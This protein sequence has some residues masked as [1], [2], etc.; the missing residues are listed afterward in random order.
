MDSDNEKNI[1]SAGEYFLNQFIL[2]DE[3]VTRMRTQIREL[4]KLMKINL[5]AG[6]KIDHESL[7]KLKHLSEKV[8]RFGMSL[9]GLRD[10][11]HLAFPTSKYNQNAA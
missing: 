10:E 4:Q 3:A 2:K 9:A 5:Q 6:L 1:L 8:K 7:K 11:F